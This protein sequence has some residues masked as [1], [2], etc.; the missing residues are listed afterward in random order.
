M[1]WQQLHL[2]C[3]EKY[4]SYTHLYDTY[5]RLPSIE[6]LIAINLCSLINFLFTNS[7]VIVHSSSSQLI[8]MW[9]CEC[10]TVFM[11]V[12][13]IVE[14]ISNGG[15][16]KKIILCEQIHTQ[17][18]HT[19]TEKNSSINQL[20]RFLKHIIRIALYVFTEIICSVCLLRYSCQMRNKNIKR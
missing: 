11:R 7:L 3:M 17:N 8:W 13:E 19:H 15:E 2:F 20:L 4:A 18:T 5:V 6:R 16:N 12:N 9:V 1:N 10:V 14:S